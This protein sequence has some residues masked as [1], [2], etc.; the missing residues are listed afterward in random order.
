MTLAAKPTLVPG[1]VYR[2]RDLGRWSANPPRLVK[3]LVHSGELVP[4]AHGLFAHPKRSRF[5]AVP[6]GDDEILRAFLDDT[7]FVVTGPEKWNTLGLGTTAVFAA[8]LVYNRKRSGEFVLGGRKFN[9][10]RVAFPDSPTAEWYVV[11]LLEHAAQAGASRAEVANA[12]ARAL[13]AGRFDRDRLRS[14]AERYAT[15][16]TRALIESATARPVS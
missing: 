13:A 1:R 12:L 7:P 16:A 8:A 4:L 10:R 15:K 3:R 11:D 2:T 6:P 5:G 14:T 9:L